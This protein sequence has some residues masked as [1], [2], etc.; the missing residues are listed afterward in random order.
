MGDSSL[1]SPLTL[2]LQPRNLSRENPVSSSLRPGSEAPVCAH[3]RGWREGAE[4]TSQIPAGQ[5]DS[6]KS[7][8]RP[9]PRG[10]AQAVPFT[11]HALTHPT[12]QVLPPGL[13]ILTLAI[14]ALPERS[15]SE[16][17]VILPG[18]KGSQGLGR[19]CRAAEASPVPS[20][21]PRPRESGRQS[22]FFF[23]FA[24]H[25]HREQISTVS[26]IIP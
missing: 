5:H 23:F 2:E 4:H 24:A 14:A 18:R 20:S 1:Q 10:E 9:R 25:T 12:P 3:R 17:Q 26:S 6:C 11:L 16:D 22:L 8:S 15:G 7:L 19:T 21:P 13:E